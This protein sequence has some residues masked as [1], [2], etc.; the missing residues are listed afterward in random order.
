MVE[1][2]KFKVAKGLLFTL[3][4]IVG[5]NIVSKTCTIVLSFQS[6]AGAAPAPPVGTLRTLSRIVVSYTV[7][8]ILELTAKPL[9]SSTS[10]TDDPRFNKSFI[11]SALMFVFN[12]ALSPS[13]KIAGIPVSG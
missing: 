8:N 9:L 7:V 3:A 1:T 12:E 11:S 4:N 5:N 13:D 10:V 6:E 2:D